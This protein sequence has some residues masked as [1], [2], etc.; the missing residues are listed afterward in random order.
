M[1]KRFYFL[2]EENDDEGFFKNI[3]KPLLID[4]YDQVQIWQHAQKSTETVIRFLRSLE[5]MGADY[6]YVADIDNFECVTGKK[7]WIINQLEELDSD[8]I[9]VVIKEIEAWYLAGIDEE[10]SGKGIEN[11][12]D[13]NEIF[14]EDFNEL[15]PEN[16]DSR[17]DFMQEIIKSFSV[18]TGKAKNDSLSYFFSKYIEPALDKARE[19]VA[20]DSGYVVGG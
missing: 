9:L 14:K 3:I 19:K 18:E 4:E 12:S 5:A 20:V 1:S 17:I 7:G 2:V 8:K 13:T 11:L 15:I 16:F 10:N 6:V